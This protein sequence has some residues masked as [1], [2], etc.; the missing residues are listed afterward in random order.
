MTVNVQC[1]AVGHV[2]ATFALHT[3]YVKVLMKE[4]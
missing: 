2:L 1:S 3:S 4:E